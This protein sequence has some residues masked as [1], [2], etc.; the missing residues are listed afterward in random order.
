MKNLLRDIGYSARTLRKSLPFTLVAL[1]TIALG[2][3]ASTAIFSVVNAVLLRPLPYTDAERLVLIWGDLRAR[4]VFDFPFPPAD[5]HDLREQGTLFEEFGAVSTGRQTVSGDDGEPERIIVAGV[6]A[7]LFSMLGM[8]TIAGRGFN[9]DDALPQA[10]PP[11]GVTAQNTPVPLP[12]ITVLSHRFWQRRYG[13]AADVL[14]RTIDLGGQRA[15]VVGVL[16]P[17]AELLFPPGTNVEQIPDVWTALRVDYAAG[18][19]INVFLRVIGKLKPGVSVAAAQSQLDGIATSL[20]QQFPIKETADLRFRVEPMHDDLVADVQPLILALMGAVLF[21]LLIACANVANLLLVRSAA[22][23][24]ELAVRAALG[25]SRSRLMMMVLAESLVL[26]TGGALIGLVFA[27]LGIQ[28]LLGLRPDGLPRMESIRLDPLV[29]G[30]TVAASFLAALAFGLVPALRASRTDVADVLREAGR[31]ACLA[32]GRMLRSG[33]VVAE[34]A[35]SFVLLIA[36]GLMVR[37]FAALQRTDP[38]FDANGLL[39]FVANARGNDGQ[40]AAF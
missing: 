11:E 6:T 25:G 8:R 4:D 15:E 40:R 9:P 28:A 13:G 17:G 27:R 36:C 3:G 38:G 32:R 12:A 1:L 22:R 34:V 5:F 30:F 29:L 33:V 21:V 23:E 2:I 10:P 37:S 16:A 31:N 20:R 14:G 18:S 35:L 39:T 26:G 19:R 7:N 24:R